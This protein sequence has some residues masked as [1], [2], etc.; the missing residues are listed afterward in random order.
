MRGRN[1]LPYCRRLPAGGCTQEQVQVM[2]GNLVSV[3]G[4]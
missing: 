3:C 2:E 1:V 4:D